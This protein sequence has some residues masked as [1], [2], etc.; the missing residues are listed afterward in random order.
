MILS[1][2]I[3]TSIIGLAIF[4]NDHKLHELTWVKFNDKEK[5]LFKK[6]DYFIEFMEKYKHINFT[7]IV[8]EKELLRFAG[9]FSNAETL[10]KLAR[11]N[12]LISGYLYRKYNVEPEYYNVQTARKTAFPLL[13]I[14]QSH[15]SKKNLM[16]EAVMNAEPTINWKYGKTGKLV[17]GSLDAVDAYVV[18]MAHIVSK[19][20]QKSSQKIKEQLQDKE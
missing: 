10:N 5:S 13:I 20:R 3:S 2:D 8:I 19:I 6:L 1:L 9:K 11:M 7:E 15:P 14:P 12:A 18:G 4:D 17:D 16:W